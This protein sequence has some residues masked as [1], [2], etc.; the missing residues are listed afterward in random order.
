MLASA[1]Q[2]DQLLVPDDGNRIQV[3]LVDRELERRRNAQVVRG[4]LEGLG[5]VQCPL[6]Q[7]PAG[8]Q[9]SVGQDR[10]VGL[11]RPRRDGIGCALVKQRVHPIAGDVR[12]DV[13]DPQ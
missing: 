2:Q 6:I 5:L 7:C 9:L 1:R 8:L 12:E 13:V 3:A 10:A 11:Q 4:W